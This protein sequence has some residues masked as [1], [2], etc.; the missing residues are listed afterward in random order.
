MLYGRALSAATL[1]LIVSVPAFGQKLTAAEVVR[2]AMP[3][4]VRILT[5]DQKGAGAGSG[6]GFA[7]RPDGIVVTNFHVIDGAYSAKAELPNG[8]KVDVLGVVELDQ[9]RDFAILKLQAIDLPTVPMG[10]SD[11]LVQGEDII[12]VGAP[13]GFTG[14]VTNGIVSRLGPLPP[15]FASVVG[16][17][18]VVQHTAAISPGN[19]GGPLLNTS[20]QVIA[21]NTFT[22]KMLSGVYFSVPINYVRASLANTDGKW[23]PMQQVAEAVAKQREQRAVAEF[24]EFVQN[25]FASHQDSE[26]LYEVLVPKSWRTERTEFTNEESGGTRHVITI[27]AS[28]QAEKATVTGWLSEGIRVHLRFPVKGNSWNLGGADEWTTQQ[29]TQMALGYR[30]TKIGQRKEAKMGDLP[31]FEQ[32]IQGESDQV[33]KTELLSLTVAPSRL[34]LATVE[35]VMPAESSELLSKIRQVFLGTIKPAWQTPQKPQ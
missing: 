3:S 16:D 15:Q 29:F 19:S 24:R 1:L 18:K 34:C 20:A 13:S 14:T 2:K 6:S 7:I 5:Y 33:S 30:N 25:N 31:A 8:D 28:R 21:I 4:V 23:M 17:H 22:L 11:S 26:G 9:A 35:I 32:I 27:F 10:N 12:A